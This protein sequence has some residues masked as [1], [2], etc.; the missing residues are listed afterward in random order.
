MTP[1]RLSVAAVAVAVL[2]LATTVTGVSAD[3][4]AAKP[5]SP[6]AV[7]DDFQQM[8]FFDHKPV[9][10]VLKYVSPN[11]IEHDPTT[12]NGR[13]GILAY[14]KKRDWSKSEMQDK[15]YREIA[16]GD[17]VV[18]HHHIVDHPGERGMAAIDIFR[19]K[20]GLIV[21]HWDVLQPVPEKP[22]N[23]LSMF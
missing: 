6:K 12:A 4:M 9:E 8:A 11:V 14:F 5:S 7:V 13:E 22:A 15:I 23:T 2:A 16:Q 10:A 19:V 1:I 20:D 21:E 18:V 3:Q 17:M